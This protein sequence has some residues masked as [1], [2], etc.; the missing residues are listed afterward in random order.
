MFPHFKETL[1]DLIKE[2]H[3]SNWSRDRIRR[4]YLFYWAYYIFWITLALRLL[5]GSIALRH[6]KFTY[7]TYDMTLN[8]LRKMASSSSDFLLIFSILT[9]FP[10]CSHLVVY[11]SPDPL[12]WE[13]MFDVLVRNVDQFKR[14]N[15]HLLINFSWKLFYKKP[16]SL[17][18]R[19]GRQLL[20][21]FRGKLVK[22]Q[23]KLKYFPHIRAQTR[24]QIILIGWYFEVLSHSLYLSKCRN[25]GLV[26]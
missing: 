20:D 13:H 10:V 12:I 25:K 8:T 23:S 24:S 4:V 3:L 1:Y 18:V 11:F 21:R 22:I 16:R 15:A 2:I 19:L 6:G 7:F 9:P 5:I 14:E 17:M 26:G